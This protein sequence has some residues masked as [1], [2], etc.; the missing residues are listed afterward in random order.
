MPCVCPHW[1]PPLLSL[2]CQ[3][4]HN[5]GRVDKNSPLCL[6]HHPQELHPFLFSAIFRHQLLL[7]GKPLVLPLH[8]A[9]LWVSCHPSSPYIIVGASTTAQ[10]LVQ[11]MAPAYRQDLNLLFCSPRGSLLLKLCLTPMG[12]TYNSSA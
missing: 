3:P 1:C 10:S 5:T 9:L 6:L 7:T 11:P 4:V 12:I 8:L 2:G